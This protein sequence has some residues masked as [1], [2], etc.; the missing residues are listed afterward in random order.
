MLQ[1]VKRILEE[2]TFTRSDIKADGPVVIADFRTYKVEVVPSFRLDD[3]RFLNAHTKDGG[4]WAFAH[5]TAELDHL[6]RADAASGGMARDLIK[7]LKAWKNTCSA[8]IRSNH[9]EIGAVV[10]IEQWEYRDKGIHY[11][12]WMVRDFFKF[13]LGFVNGRAKPAGVDEWKDLGDL[14]ASKAQSAYDRAVKACEFEQLDQPWSAVNEWQKIFGDQFKYDQS[15]HIA[16][17]AAG[18]LK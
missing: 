7:M 6:N 18:L 13:L 1:H 3:G 2:Q 10:F 16:I 15:H 17:L 5:P 11:Y 4:R 9:L 8:P 14:W 12:D